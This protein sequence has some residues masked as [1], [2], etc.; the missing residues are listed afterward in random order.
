M[1]MGNF[2]S[3]CFRRENFQIHCEARQMKMTEGHPNMLSVR[4]APNHIY[5]Y[6]CMYVCT[7]VRM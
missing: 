5:V 3:P 4:D 1:L 2:E 7:Y 6:V